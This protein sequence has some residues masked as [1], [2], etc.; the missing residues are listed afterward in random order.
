MEDLWNNKS[1]DSKVERQK[2]ATEGGSI[3]LHLLSNTVKT[4]LLISSE[5]H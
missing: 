2:K 5:Q 3:S 4:E 1:L